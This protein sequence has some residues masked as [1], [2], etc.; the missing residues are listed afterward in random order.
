M[1]CHLTADVRIELSAKLA[2]IS[3]TR[4]RRPPR[5]GF[6][7][8]F[9]AGGGAQP[10][11]L[12]E[13]GRGLP[14]LPGANAAGGQLEPVQRALAGQRGAARPPGI[15]AS[16][17]GDEGRIPPQ[18]LMVAEILVSEENAGHALPRQAAA[19]AHSEFRAAVIAEARYQQVE[20]VHALRGEAGKK[21]AGVRGD[22]S[23]RETGLDAGL[24]H[25]PGGCA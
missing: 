4:M 1:S 23:A 8:G 24:A 13:A 12:P 15:K 11:H 21:D 19:A 10:V 3:H 18:L 17:N 9:P 20:Q 16:Q 5:R 14:V 6:S 2:C 25:A 22:R 7:A